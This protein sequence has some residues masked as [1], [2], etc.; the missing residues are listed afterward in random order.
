[1][2][3]NKKFTLNTFKRRASSKG[4]SLVELLVV[5]AIVGILIA[6]GYPS[7]SDFVKK[8]RRT[9][10][11]L[12]LMEATQAMERC[13]STQFT[14]ATCTLSGALQ[15]SPEG[16]YTIALSPAPTASSFTIVATPQAIQLNDKECL[17]MSIDHLGRRT[18]TPGTAG[19]D[20]ND[21]WN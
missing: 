1:M 19:Q 2:S 16:Y 15:N 21:C 9:D 12:A 6:V 8:S 14:Y 17:T 18:S 11:T 3:A 4:F 7:Y 10:G 20:D 13:K 5:I